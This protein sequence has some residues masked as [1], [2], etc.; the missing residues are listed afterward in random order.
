[1]VFTL[2]DHACPNRNC[3]RDISA[4]LQI[5]SSGFQHASFDQPALGVCAAEK[6]E[7][8]AKFFDLSERATNDFLEPVKV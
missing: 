5:D 3:I 7:I 6:S 2:T 1:M 8:G 4:D